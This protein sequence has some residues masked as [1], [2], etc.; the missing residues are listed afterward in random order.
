MPP[1]KRQLTLEEAFFP[2]GCAAATE[3]VTSA[4]VEHVCMNLNQEIACFLSANDFINFYIALRSVQLNIPI[5]E[6][7]FCHFINKLAQKRR[8]KLSISEISA[9]RTSISLSFMHRCLLAIRCMYDCEECNSTA[10]YNNVMSCSSIQSSDLEHGVNYQQLTSRLPIP[11]YINA[12][13]L[14]PKINATLSYK[15]LLDTN[16]NYIETFGSVC[17]CTE[18][19]CGRM[20][21][22]SCAETDFMTCDQCLLTICIECLDDPAI[23][24]NTC[25]GCEKTFC[26]ECSESFCCDVCYSTYCVKCVIKVDSEI[27]MRQCS[28]CQGLYCLDD[29]CDGYVITCEGGCDRNICDGCNVNIYFCSKC[30]LPKCSDCGISYCDYCE[31]FVCNNCGIYCCKLC[32]KASCSRCD[33]KHSSVDSNDPFYFVY[34]Q[35]FR[36]SKKTISCITCRDLMCESCSRGHFITKGCCVK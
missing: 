36:G 17:R 10:R 19:G 7:L 8:I 6:S 27:L 30:T 16:F 15:T 23:D 5:P 35:G 18:V 31:D 21:C 24:I 33:L 14:N 20:Y 28:L 34:D 11:L 9:P 26:T 29:R 25:N 13:S 32:N 12:A 1:K 3:L 22:A 2:R 4:A